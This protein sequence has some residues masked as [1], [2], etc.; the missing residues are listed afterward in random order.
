MPADALTI[1]D[2]QKTYPEGTRALDGVSLDVRE[3]SFFGLLG[4]NGAGKTTLIGIVSGLVNRSA[5][6]VEVF[7]TDTQRQ[8]NEA[9][10]LIGLVPQ[11]FNFNPFE[12]V[13]D[14]VVQQA[15]YYGIPRRIAI[16]RTEEYL[17]RLGLWEKRRHTARSLSGGLKRRLLIARGLVHQPKL[18]FLDEPTAGVDVELRRSMWE[19]LTGINEGG[20]TVVLTTHYLE[21]AEQLCDEIAI[22]NSGAIIE[23]TT[24]KDLL[25]RLHLL[26]YLVDL[27]SPCQDLPRLQSCEATMVDPSCLE[28]TIRQGQRMDQVFQELAGHDIHIVS[29]RNK[30]NRLE[31]L[32]LDLI[33]SP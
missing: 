18:L 14:I 7:G 8:P 33:D 30:S 24:K 31:E 3:G 27:E 32:F 10:Q 15:G 17:H 20:T 13:I 19:F 26:T 22:I 25:G 16:P 5:G 4:P 28:I 6:T 23:H 2:L 12:C 11:E 1:R 9:K 21:E 29:M